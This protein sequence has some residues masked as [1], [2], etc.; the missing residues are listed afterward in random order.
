MA[1]GPRLF[2]MQTT[3]VLHAVLAPLGFA[4]LSL[5]YFRRFGY[6]TPLAT[7]A[8]FV[9]LIVALDAGLIAPFVERSWAM[10]ASVLGTWLP[11]ALIFAATWFTGLW[12]G[13][14]RVAG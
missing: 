9:G 2:T 14:R 7:A 10:F 6:T 4:A 5:L 1:I 12:V 11:F 8:A 13:S 3:L